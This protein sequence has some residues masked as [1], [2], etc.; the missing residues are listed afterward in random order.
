MNRRICSAALMALVLVFPVVASC[1]A[2]SKSASSTPVASAGGKGPVLA[3]SGPP[4]A[5]LAKCA[6]G[7][8]NEPLQDF[9]LKMFSSMTGWGLGQCTSGARPSFP[10]GST[11]NCTWP[12]VESMGIL[13]TSDGGTTWTDVSP[14]S[15]TNR[16]WHHAQFFLDANHAWVGEV[17]RTADACASQVTMFMT[18]DGGRS[19]QQGGTIPIKTATPTD[20]V[21]NMFGP[22]DYMDFIDLQHGWL[23]VVSPP[24]NPTPGSMV[25]Q[26][27]LYATAD[28]GLH[29]RA[30]GTNPGS[31]AAAGL[32]GCQPTT[33]MPSS[34]VSFQ[35]ATSGW[36]EI[37][38]PAITMLTTRDGGASW[39]ANALPTCACQVLR[40]QTFD[41]N[42][43][44]ITGEQ[45]S[46]VMLWT[47]DA[48][49]TWAQRRV[50]QAAMTEFSFIDPNDGWMVGIAQLAKSYET[51][52]Y[53]TADGGQTWSLLGKPGFAT[54]TSNPNLY[55]PI[56]GVQFV[57]ADAGFVTLGPE[58]APQGTRDPTAPQ[59]QILS[60][61]D[62]GRT[63]SSVLK[64]VPSAP[65]STNYSQIG[66][67]N[68]DLSPVEMASATTAWARGGLRTTDG[69]A[70]W[71]DVSSPALREGSATPLYPSGYTDFFLDGDHAWQA[72]IYGSKATCSD[73]LTTFATADG[74]KTWQQSSS[75]DLNLPSGYRAGVVQL[76]FTSAQVGWLW[77]PTGTQVNNDPFSFSLSGAYLY[78]TSDGGLS[79]RRVSTLSNSQ[80]QNIPA[81]AGSQ[82]CKPSLGQITFSSSTVG[83]LS[84]NCADPGMLVTRDGGVTWKTLSVVNGDCQC[85]PSLPTFVD[86]SHGFIQIYG[87]AGD[88]RLMATSD[89]GAT[90]RTLPP[91][92][93]SGFIMA[94]T[95]ADTGN[96]WALVT[97]PG[98]TKMSGGKDSLYRSGDGGQTWSLVQA[99][100]P[101]GRV[102]SLLFA[103]D[104][105]GMVAQPRNATWSYDAAGFATAN[106]TVLALTTD[107]G[108]TWKVFP[109]AI[110]T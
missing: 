47:A 105:A 23:M 49:A 31:S 80:L 51:V 7:A 43:A 106:D 64:L 36:L 21:F 93:S 14:P 34:D 38:C 53:R 97:P 71:R 99:G 90:W 46:P 28:G 8:Q 66:Q 33:Y 59:L 37:D 30:L 79:W 26:A 58:A 20:D 52:V 16:T 11:I 63:W 91:L 3:N 103:A 102:Y 27:T 68:G 81:P 9:A 25:T 85:S 65:C 96:L 24:S 45:G 94:I 19:W 72:G 82:D 44:L 22:T 70:H 55:Y 69:G 89:G 98:W 18:A 39:V 35:S 78:T 67:G 17:S 48:G 12:Q 88:T 76:G 84:L 50:P 83:F 42:H 41:A 40:P 73:H 62:G 61:A 75:V 108:H 95:F 4:Q 101:L 104:G 15:V 77:V 57:S 1:Q 109:P 110:A 13:R 87:N 92:P 2:F 10:N 107:G 29:W 54:A 74:G 86:A 6:V 100:V 56:A 32:P 5:N 60:T